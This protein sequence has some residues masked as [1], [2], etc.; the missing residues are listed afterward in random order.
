MLQSVNTLFAAPFRPPHRT[1]SA[2]PISPEAY[3]AG[4]VEALEPVQTPGDPPTELTSEDT[5]CDDALPPWLDVLRSLALEATTEVPCL[6]DSILGQYPSHRESFLLYRDCIRYLEGRY[7]VAYLVCSVPEDLRKASIQDL[8]VCFGTLVN[9]VADSVVIVGLPDQDV[10]E[11]LLTSILPTLPPPP[12]AL[13]AIVIAVIRTAKYF[14]GHNTDYCH[15]SHILC[16]LLSP[17]RWA[18]ELTESDHYHAL[19]LDCLTHHLKDF[20]STRLSKTASPMPYSLESCEELALPGLLPA[21]DLVVNVDDLPVEIDGDLVWSIGFPLDI[22]WPRL[23]TRRYESMH[24]YPI[25]PSPSACATLR[26][27]KCAVYTLQD[28]AALWLSAMIFGLLEAITQ[29][30]IPESILLVPGTDGEETVIDGPRILQVIVLWLARKDQGHGDRQ[31][32]LEHGREVAQLLRRALRALTDEFGVKTAP[33]FSYAGIPE[34]LETSIR[35]SI[36]HLLVILWRVMANDRLTGWGSLPETTGAITYFWGG[37]DCWNMEFSLHDW[38]EKRMLDAGWCPNVISFLMRARDSTSLAALIPHLVR[39]GPYVRTELGEHADCSKYACV[40]HTVVDPDAYKHR[41][42]RPSCECDSVK[43]HLGEVLRLLDNGVVPVVIYDGSDLR[44]VPAQENA[45]I[46][47]SHVWSEGMG[48]TTDVGLPTCLVEHISSLAKSLLP[49]HDGAFWM[50]SLCVPSAH[51][52]RKKAIRLMA[53]TYRNAAKVLVID[54]SVRTSCHSELTILPEILL[55]IATS[56]WVRRVWTLQE[57][58]LARELY[59]EF[60]DGAVDCTEFVIPEGLLDLVP[61]LSFRTAFETPRDLRVWRPPLLL[62]VSLLQ[63]RA[64]TKDEDELIAI[65]GLLPLHVKTDKLLAEGHGPNLAERRMKTFLLQ[66]R[67]IPLLVPFDSSPRST[68]PGFTWAPCML[69]MGHWVNWSDDDPGYGICTEEGLVGRYH[70]ALLDKPITMP[71]ADLE[72]QSR[73]VLVLHPQSKSFHRLQLCERTGGASSPDWTLCTFDAL[74]FVREGMGSFASTIS[75][76]PCIGV[77]RLSVDTVTPGSIEANGT[78]HEH[79]I[80]IEYVVR[81]GLI[82]EST[83]TTQ[84]M[85]ELW[86]TRHVPAARMGDLQ[87]IWVKLS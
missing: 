22:P 36:A 49:E 47:I 10:G 12:H 11:Q 55:R 5:P 67:V 21:S 26:R 71:P 9:L 3:R 59:F 15:A 63:G 40:L 83:P 77:K 57:G 30:R 45:Y 13:R 37:L 87:D 46:A 56:A 81:C 24:G 42:A 52:Q 72:S 23:G 33:I 8:P 44:V 50:D 6:D 35:Y 51:E 73:G 58:I 7:P 29:M 31:Q 70:L 43:P 64:T 4:A 74:L 76:R 27:P 20:W 79:T 41:H 82:R 34:E 78:S 25:C 61:V 17:S 39:L 28:D 69:S 65:S 48:S 75:L 14:L 38:Y 84:E 16:T 80:A 32:D 66:L 85:L 62:L 86:A 1:Q 18:H 53:D 60:V 68:L 19:F 54:D 2:P